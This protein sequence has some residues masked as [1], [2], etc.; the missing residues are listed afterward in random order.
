[1]AYPASIDEF[2]PKTDDVDDVMAADVNELQTAIEAIETE[3]GTDPAGSCTDVTTRLAH[4]INDAGMLEFDAAA[5]LT[6]ADGAI[7]VTQNFHKVDTE[8]SASS[9]DL[10]TISGGS[11]GLW[12]VLRLNNADHDVVIKHG[13]GNIYC[14][15]GVDITLSGVHQFA[16]GIYDA[17]LSFWYIGVAAST[18]TSGFTDL[19]ESSTEVV[20]NEG[21]SATK[22]FRVESDTEANMIF[23]DANADTNGALYLGGTT[24]GVKIAKGGAVTLLGTATLL[25]GLTGSA[26]D[27]V[28]NEGSADI[29]F[30]VES[31]GQAKA[32]FVDAG[33]DLIGMFTDTPAAALD[34]TQPSSSAAVPV[35]ELEQ[36]DVDDAFVNFV[37]TSAAD[38]TKSI[39]TVNGDGSVEGPKNYSAAAG[40]AFAGMVRCEINGT[41]GWIP[42]Y[43]ADVA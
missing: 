26:N 9:D 16:I 2:T 31:N 40:W 10:D 28:I 41:V 42:Y 32:I 38:Q 5:N 17:A 33:N 13:T 12:V 1:M 11:A 14:S 37:G 39:S 35:L 30:R 18:T 25:P 29:D 4:S 21:G 8:S 19:T 6:I 15:S 22:D 23:V 34:I 27:V 3:L 7:T 24:N 36:L 20:V 43:T